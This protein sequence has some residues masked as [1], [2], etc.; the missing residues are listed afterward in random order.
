[1]IKLF[2]QVYL[3]NQQNSIIPKMYM[4]KTI[5]CGLIAQITSYSQ[6]QV[7][8]TIISLLKWLKT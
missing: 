8:S 4:S 1:M 2:L 3:V 7:V 5:L 6:Y